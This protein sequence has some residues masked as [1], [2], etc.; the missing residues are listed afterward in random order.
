MTEFDLSKMEAELSALFPSLRNPSPLRVIGSGFNS[1][2]VETGGGTVFR[3]AKN[4][5][6]RE[7]YEKETSCLPILA[8]NIPFLIPNPKWYSKSSA[9]FPF[10]VIGYDKIPG[11]PLHPNVP[12]NQHLSLLARDTAKFLFALH[13]ISPAGL[14][15]E[16]LL[17]PASK[18]ETQYHKVLPVL[19]AELTSTEFRLIKQWWDGFLADPKMQKYNLVIRHGDLWYENMLA[20]P[21]MKRLIG[22]LDWEKLSIG[23]PA[24]DFATLFHTG[25]RFVRLVIQAYQSLGGE[26]DENFEYR[27]QRLWEAREFDG[28]DYAI[29]FEDPVELSDA[30]QKLRRG[31]ILKRTL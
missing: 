30:V 20:D 11:V 4:S 8:P 24:Q 23:D 22:I 27:M 21:P 7:G 2:V 6:A 28:L 14:H 13:H 10:G 26:L 9:Y 19:K 25:E 12:N 31:P 5:A 29:Q 16:N 15:F 17:D 3:I 18:W 1:I